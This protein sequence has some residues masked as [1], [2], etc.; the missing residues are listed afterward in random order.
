[1]SVQS[2]LK[3]CERKKSKLQYGNRVKKGA[4]GIMYVRW[5]EDDTQA[6][7]SGSATI[8][9]IP[10]WLL[11]VDAGRDNPT[12]CFRRAGGGLTNI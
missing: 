12:S 4:K 3:R 2:V 7:F 9:L 11:C 10:L 5:D 1:M 6:D 8:F